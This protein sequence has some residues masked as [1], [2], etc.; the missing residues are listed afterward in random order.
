M[1]EKKYLAGMEKP[2]MEDWRDA[3]IFGV[4]IETQRYTVRPSVYGVIEDGHGQIAVVRT[5]QGFTLPG[6][7]I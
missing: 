5:P 2:L 6:G 1:A 7:G 4:R 3:P